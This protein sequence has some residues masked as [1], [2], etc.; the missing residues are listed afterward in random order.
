MNRRRKI[1]DVGFLAVYW[2][3]GTREYVVKPRGALSDAE[4]YFTDDID[5]AIGTA[6]A[7]LA[8]VVE[9]AERKAGWDPNP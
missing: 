2:D 3:S 7:W 6:R 9:N 1:T 5:D 4:A 8:D